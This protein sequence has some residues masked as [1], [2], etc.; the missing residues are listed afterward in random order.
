MYRQRIPVINV[1]TRMSDRCGDNEWS[2]E[3]SAAYIVDDISANEVH[4]LLTH[5]LTRPRNLF[6]NG[7]GTI[8]ESG[9]FPW[10]LRRITHTN[11]CLYIVLRR[12]WKSSPVYEDIIWGTDAFGGICPRPTWLCW[13]WRLRTTCGLMLSTFVGGD[14][15]EVIANSVFAIYPCP[16][17][18][19]Y[20][21]ACLPR[22]PPPDIR[23]R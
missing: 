9:F 14:W 22:V 13:Y 11:V 17:P 5:F 2:F 16:P 10:I 6:M 3:E 19:R 15:P 4:L 18:K 1:W 12:S 8:S 23:E 21:T 20:Y 7:W